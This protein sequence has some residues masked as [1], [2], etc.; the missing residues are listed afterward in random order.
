MYLKGS[1]DGYKE[2]RAQS[3]R[4][5]LKRCEACGWTLCQAKL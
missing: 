2:L 3:D 4:Q 5:A 1:L